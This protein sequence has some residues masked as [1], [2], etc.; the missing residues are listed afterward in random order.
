MQMC[1]QSARR[2][3]RSEA[4]RVDR[5]DSVAGY[6]APVP[7]AEQAAVV[8]IQRLV[9]QQQKGQ[10]VAA[11]LIEARGSVIKVRTLAI[12]EYN[13]SCVP[14]HAFAPLQLCDQ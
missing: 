4:F 3:A 11:S 2:A 10:R 6:S 12:Y 5:Y 8:R 7:V 9:R 13:Y 14:A 1:T